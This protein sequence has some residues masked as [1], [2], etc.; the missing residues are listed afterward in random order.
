MINE[1]L[2]A[3]IKSESLDQLDNSTFKLLKEALAD[4]IACSIAGSNTKATQIAKEFAMSQW[5]TGRSSLFLF[6]E[7][8]T[9]A[10]AAF[11]NSTMANELDLDD[12]HRLT[13]GHPGAIIFPAVL[14]AAEDYNV[15]G[16]NF[17]TALLVGYEVGIRA[18]ILAHK[19]RPEYHC[20]GSWGSIGA[21]AGV[22]R[23]IGLSSDKLEHALGIAEYFGTYSPRMRCIEFPSMLK[24]GINWGCMT[25]ISASYLAKGGYTGIPSLFTMEEAVELTK[26]LCTYYRIRE[27]YIKPH[28]CCRWAQPAIEG[29]KVIKGECSLSAANIKKIIIHTFTE[30]ATLSKKY[31]K[32]TEEAQYNLCF[33][34]AAYLVYGEVGP[35][36]VLDQL[37]DPLILNIMDKIEVI[38]DSEFNEEFPKKALS[39]V[40]IITIDGSVYQSPVM[41]AKGDYDFP[42]TPEEKKEKFFWLTTPLIGER[43]A[44]QL[45]DLI[46]NVESLKRIRELTEVLASTKDK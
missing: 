15:S 23:M 37:D 10:G 4:I 6:P 21:A 26:E 22:S 25:G 35:K 43:V 16:E 20:T 46:H 28:A 11:V 31:P 39:R 5:G 2:T 40:K 13:K 36:E 1:T 24:D 17:L 45:F 3:Y 30:S 19:L 29:I 8:L 44:S 42:L 41:Q 12:G 38:I 18:G 7:K 33:P 9:A 14:A 32:T 27:L 34:A